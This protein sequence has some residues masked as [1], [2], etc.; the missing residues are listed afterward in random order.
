M[1]RGSRNIAE[2]KSA[3]IND[4]VNHIESTQQN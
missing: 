3:L 1:V 4:Y 2:R